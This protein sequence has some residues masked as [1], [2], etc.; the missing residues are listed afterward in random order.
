MKRSI[1][2]FQDLLILFIV[3]LF[4]FP[5]SVA[6]D[7]ECLDC[8][9]NLIENS[10]HFEAVSCADCHSDV[11]DESHIDDGAAKVSCADC[12]EDYAESVNNDIHHRLKDR[13][14]N[15]PDCITCHGGHNIIS[16]SGVTNKVKTY[17][18]QC[19]SD[20]ILANPYHSV[21]V[22]NESCFEC[23]DGE[24][25]KDL[26]A[27]SVHNK[28]NCAD[29]HNYI[30]NNMDTHPADIEK[31]QRADC[32]MCHTEIANEH[33]ESIHGISLIEGIDEAAQCW[34]CHGSHSIKYVDDP[35][36]S[37]AAK[38]IPET[39][40]K[41]HNDKDLIEK[42]DIATTSSVKS[43]S[44]S[45][46]GK[47]VA[48]GGEAATCIS[49]HGV[50]NIKSRVQENSSISTFNIPNTC[51]QCHSEITDEY[52][53][54]IHWIRAKQ[55]V[56]L[57]PVCTDCHLEHGV[58]AVN[59]L[60]H[61]RIEMNKMQERTCVECHTNP[62]ITERFGNEGGQVSEYQ[63]SYHGLAVMRGDED[64][65]M[66]IDCHAVHKILPEKHPGST[67]NE[68]NVVQ[69]CQ[70]CHEGATEVFAK[71]YS[72]KSQSES[73]AYVEGI[74]ESIYILLIVAVIGG[75]I[76]HN[77]IIFFS[78]LRSKR[79]KEKNLIK[80]PRFTT[81][82]VIQHILLFTTFITL[83]ITGFALK[84][85]ESF[86]AEGLLELGLTEP[87]RQ[88]IH[89]SCG[90]ALLALSFYHLLYLLFTVRGREVLYKMLPTLT[91]AK[92]V[93]TTIGYY[94]GIV[95][96]K[97]AYDK[98]DYTEKAE[99]WA[100]I[101]GT[102]VMGVT[103][104]ILWFPTMVG[105]WA[106]VWFIKVSELIHFYEAIL[107]TLAIVVWHWFFVIF[108]PSEYPMS[109]AWVDGKMTLSHYK[110]HHKQHL[111]SVMLDL[112][113]LRE[114]NKK[115]EQ[116]P[117]YSKLFIKALRKQNIDPFDLLRDQMNEDEELR[118]WIESKAAV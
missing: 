25:T 3:F 47:I 106:P 84:Y 72:H 19:H 45:V 109:F 4:P 43:Y 113:L 33:R 49:C 67:V 8:H 41:C 93:F 42:F 39:C 52:E 10:V 102:V 105:D 69:T 103:G 57:S 32:Y 118:D 12:H 35:G 104:L 34:D 54:S 86:W 99:Y 98:Y 68:K 78:E 16:P 66:C 2:L 77:L 88:L 91:D 64:A 71:S 11:V 26:L 20:I 21:A 22:G 75:M 92:Q 82:E 112:F 46:H 17:C 27:A 87:V 53:K 37:V 28:L 83:S 111:R 65:A 60:E 51:G 30:S 36:S 50:H 61:G 110:S 94:L 13:V 115:E 73:A 95:K 79:L 44:S 89:K 81:N 56:R 100:L 29:C 96:S 1:I 48:E 59:T 97:P 114:G 80:V 58:N 18:S 107:A 6:Q 15:P 24:G 85:P 62:M 76:V 101:W 9:E 55:G 7:L 5:D 31:S 117:N 108:K 70:K 38:N 116:L 63:D 90:A 23:H 40:G 14:K 74:V